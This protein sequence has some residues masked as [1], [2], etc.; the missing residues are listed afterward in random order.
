MNSSQI[1]EN[2]TFSILMA[3]FNNSKFIEEAIESVLSQSYQYW[4]LIIVDDC[5][6]DKSIEKIN[7]FLKDKRIK[8]ISNNSNL[9]YGGALKTA[10]DAANNE[11]LAILDPDD[12][13]HEKALEI[14][15]KAYRENP[16]YGFIYSTTWSCDS[17]L[18]NCK[19]VNWIGP[20]TPVKSNIFVPKISHLKTFRKDMYEKTTG[21]DP[22]QKRSVDKDIIYKL[23]EI[24]KFKFVNVPLYYY[25][26]HESG[27][28]QGK[29]KFQ[30]RI[31]LYIAKCKA[32]RRRL[33]TNIPNISL[34]ALYLE[35]Y[36]ITFHSLIK[37][38]KFVI[39]AFK[40]YNLATKILK[41][42]PRLNSINFG[43]FNFLKKRII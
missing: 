25:R 32:Y 2:I 10:S 35:Y 3:N 38:G 26:Q 6:T 17:E 43:K 28:S 33:N 9:G 19:I 30:A 13:L 7:P 5:S 22:N 29:N 21:F 39:K 12:K 18:K 15:A 20:D 31:Y 24:T 27:I 4:E 14:M 8:L 11:I 16:D 40:I 37:F 34:E 41:K 42:Y 23:E 1:P 36:K